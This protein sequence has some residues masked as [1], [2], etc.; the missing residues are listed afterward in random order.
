MDDRYRHTYVDSALAARFADTFTRMEYA[1]KNGG[2]GH[3]GENGAHPGW[4]AFG[5][6]IDAQ[7]QAVQDEDFQRAATFLLAFPA[8]KQV[9][10]GEHLAFSA[11]PLDPKQSR[12]QQVLHVVRAVR[13]NLQHGG[14]IQPE[15]EKEKERNQALVSAS[16]RVLE[17]SAELNKRAYELYRVSGRSL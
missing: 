3:G 9:Y 5:N 1:L 2:F 11:L 7:F 13:N 8:R 10:E 15:G 14:K 6:A 17:V 12:A 4:D 16:L